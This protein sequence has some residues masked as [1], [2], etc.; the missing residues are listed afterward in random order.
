MPKLIYCRG[1]D[2][3]APRVAQAAGAYY[4][5]RDN[6]TGYSRPFM[7]D[8]DFSR[9]LT[10]QRWQKYL[11]AIE[12]HQPEIALTPDYFED[13]PSRLILEWITDLQSAGV[14]RVAVCP[15]F[16]GAV[17]LTPPHCI[18]AVSVPTTYA[19]FMP[20]DSEVANR[21]L[22]LLG[23]HPDQ[24]LYIMRHRYPCESVVSVDA[25][26]AGRKAGLGQYWSV[27]EG[28]WKHAP[29]RAFTDF[30]LAVMSLKATQEYFQ[31]AF[32]PIRM[33]KRVVKCQSRLI[34]A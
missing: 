16:T 15:K 7:L 21:D 3:D 30:E 26:I 9:T 24:Q 27:R 23:G 5:Y 28:G 1:G 34:A 13:V 22:H 14:K 31:D 10:S 11:K 29:K 33:R 8:W 12:A 4:G 25:N 17:Q 2:K 6:Y 20:A 32:A 19:G 18:I